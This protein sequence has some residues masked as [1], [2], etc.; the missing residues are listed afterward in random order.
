[1]I[2][3]KA[4]LKQQLLIANN[5]AQLQLAGP[6]QGPLQQNPPGNPQ[7]P[8]QPDYSEQGRMIA[9]SN[10]PAF[11]EWQNNPHKT[12]KKGKKWLEKYDLLHLYDES[13]PNI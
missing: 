2:N 3:E 12:I 5:P 9:L 8:Y 1:M 11:V 6:Q 4:R 13:G 10:N 7:L